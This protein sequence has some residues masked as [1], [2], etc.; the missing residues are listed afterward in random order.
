MSTHIRR[1]A[2]RRIVS[3]ENDIFSM[4]ELAADRFAATPAAVKPDPE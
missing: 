2:M 3:R 4:L 1:M